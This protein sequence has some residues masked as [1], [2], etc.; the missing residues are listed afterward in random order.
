MVSPPSVATDALK[1]LE[2]LVD[3]HPHQ[4]TESRFWQPG[5]DFMDSYG[6]QRWGYLLLFWDD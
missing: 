3:R 5:L 4:V 6:P 2:L 1:L